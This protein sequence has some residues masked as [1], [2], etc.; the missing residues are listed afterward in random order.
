MKR[1]VFRDVAPCS[2]VGTDRRSKEHIASIIRAMSD[3]LMTEA[4][5][6]SETSVN[7]YQM[8]RRNISEDNHL[9]KAFSCS[10]PAA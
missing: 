4:A 6:S 2:L 8:T 1:T 10:V 3:A 9:Q 5:S 7:I